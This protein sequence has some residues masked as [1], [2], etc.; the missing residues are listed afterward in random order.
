MKD[1]DDATY[2]ITVTEIDWETDGEDVDLP[3]TM[4]VPSDLE[5]DEIADYLS[6]QKG[7]LVNGFVIADACEAQ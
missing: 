5:E 3:T 2:E 4:D 6:N 1:Y 7:W